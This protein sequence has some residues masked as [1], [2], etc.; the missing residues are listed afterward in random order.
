MIQVFPVA[1]KGQQR[2]V[3]LK[4]LLLIGEAWVGDLENSGATAEAGPPF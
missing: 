4:P 1:V 3:S 2:R